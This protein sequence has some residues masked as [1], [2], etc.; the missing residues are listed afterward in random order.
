MVL[1]THTLLLLRTYLTPYFLLNQ[2]HKDYIQIHGGP[3][4]HPLQ[5]IYLLFCSSMMDLSSKAGRLTED[6][7]GGLIQDLPG[8]VPRSPAISDSWPCKAQHGHPVQSDYR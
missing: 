4:Q 6:Y 3:Y 5:H 8:G 1:Y 7:Q 2:P